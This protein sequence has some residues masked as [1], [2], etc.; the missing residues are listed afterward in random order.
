M[1]FASAEY[2]IFLPLVALLF[3]LLRKHRTAAV[4]VLLTG[5]YLFY[6]SW[7]IA[8]IGLIIFSTVLDYFC[9]LAMA[10]AKRTGLR[11]LLLIISLTGNLGVLFTFKYFNFFAGSLEDIIAWGGGQVSLPELQVLLPVGISF[12]TF[13]TLSYTIDIYRGRLRPTKRFLDFALFVSFFPQLVAG[14]IIRASVFL[15]QLK[16]RFTF[17]SRRSERGL[18]LVLLGLFKKVV[19]ADLL[20]LNL[21]DRVFDVPLL[22]SGLENML[23]LYG[24]AFQIY[25]DFS[26]YSNI[27]IGSALILGFTFPENFHTP[28]K[29]ADL[30]EFWHRWHISLSTW[31]RDYLYIPLGG[32]RRGPARTYINLLITMV[33]GGLWHGAGWNF[34]IWGVIHGTGL[35]FCR[36]F[37]SVCPR[38]D[39]T[40]RRR[41]WTRLPA[42]IMT[43]H[44]VCFAWIFF[45]CENLETARRMIINITDMGLG[46]DHITPRILLVLA[47]AALTHFMPDKLWQRLKIGFVCLPAFGQAMIALVAVALFYLVSASKAVPF[48]YFQF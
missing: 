22:Y 16:N 20:A 2:L 14:P 23:A 40:V 12:Y 26:G 30:R 15:P 34:L 35:A 36:G 25:N 41:W 45:R 29:A 44:V 28:Y 43:F 9:G 21:V 11:R 38:L 46:T 24:Y 27:A 6:M 7:N 5:S 48:I 33:L 17:L 32:N 39:E 31:L 8:Y 1:L 4:L 3:W 42:I 13:Q 19:I 18:Y 37:N 47:L 10:K